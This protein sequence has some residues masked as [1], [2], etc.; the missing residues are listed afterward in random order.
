MLSTQAKTRLRFADVAALHPTS[1]SAI[2]PCR[3]MVVDDDEWM[4]T[5]LASVLRSARY[6]VD[7]VDSGEEALRLLR[8]APYDIMLTDCLMPGMNGLALCQRV[9][10]E[11][12]ENSPYIVMLTVKDTQADRDAGLESGADEYL[13][14]GAPTSEVLA[15]LKLGRTRLRRSSAP[16]KRL[17][18]VPLCAAHAAR[19]RANIALWNSYLP[20]TCVRSMVRLGWDYTT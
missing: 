9:R 2:P 14:K 11:F 1:A 19:S 8:A 17:F 7:A 15:K 13:I 20:S 10:A 6:A 4:R 12:P 16:M 18:H 5:Y 3:L